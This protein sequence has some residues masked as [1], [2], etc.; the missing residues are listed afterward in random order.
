MSNFQSDRERNHHLMES[1]LSITKK[2]TQH[3]HKR[4]GQDSGSSCER[5][6]HLSLLVLH[7]ARLRLLGGTMGTQ[8]LLMEMIWFLY[9]PSAL[10]HPIGRLMSDTHTWKAFRLISY[11]ILVRYVLD[12]ARFVLIHLTQWASLIVVEVSEDKF[13]EYV[14]CRHRNLRKGCNPRYRYDNYYHSQRVYLRKLSQTHGLRV[15]TCFA[16]AVASLKANLP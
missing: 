15:Y 11:K 5:W 3:K 16:S 13:S 14:K 10:A 6:G 7:Q 9:H 8:P 12:L 1:S 4:I 2:M